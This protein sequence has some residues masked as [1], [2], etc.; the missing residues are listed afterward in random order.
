MQPEV[1]QHCETGRYDQGRDELRS[2]DGFEDEAARVPSVE[3]DGK[4]SD[5]VEQKI[6][7][8]GSAWERA[9]TPLTGKQYSQDEQH[10]HCFVGLGGVEWDS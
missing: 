10:G 4:S 1:H 3:F 6:G 7:P 9:P 5:T 2:G 8:E